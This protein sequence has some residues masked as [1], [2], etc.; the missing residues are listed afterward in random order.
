MSKKFVILMQKVS[1]ATEGLKMIDDAQLDYR[2]RLASRGDIGDPRVQ[3]RADELLSSIKGKLPHLMSILPLV[4]NGSSYA[5]ISKLQLRL[6]TK[7]DRYLKSRLVPDSYFRKRSIDLDW[8]IKEWNKVIDEEN[9]LNRIYKVVAPF[10]SQMET[11][12]AKK[13]ERLINDTKRQEALAREVQTLKEDIK[14]VLDVD[15]SLVL[16][17][18]SKVITVAVIADW[19]SYWK[20]NFLK[21]T[22]GS[23][24]ISLDHLKSALKQLLGFISESRQIV[25]K[26]VIPVEKELCQIEYWIGYLYASDEVDWS[27]CDESSVKNLKIELGTVLTEFLTIPEL[28]VKGITDL[29]PLKKAVAFLD[30][31][32]EGFALTVGS[33]LKAVNWDW[34]PGFN[35]DTEDPFFSFGDRHAVKGLIRHK[36]KE[37]MPSSDK[38]A[39][40]TR[41]QD[42]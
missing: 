21:L 13:A 20:V 35:D 7:F 17:G 34:F 18:G 22:D 36:P 14:I 33:V 2:A 5:S 37:G 25:E 1:L 16:S 42:V 27:R 6:D 3:L 30:S 26:T 31:R 32:Y 9:E 41:K 15:P 10:R 11:G 12:K 28:W 24:D 29:V 8:M 23:L 19:Q 40:K 39:S 38:K 4:E